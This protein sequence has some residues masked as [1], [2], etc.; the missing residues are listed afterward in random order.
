MS[1][2][3]GAEGSTIIIHSTKFG[4]LDVPESSVIEFR[5][6]LIGLPSA[7]RF[8]MF[9]YKAPFSWLHSV[10]DPSLAF[11]VVNGF[12]FG[13]ELNFKPPYGDKDIDLQQGDEFAILVI[14]TVRTDPRL[15]TAN[16]KA[17]LFVNLKNRKGTQIIFDDPRLTTRYSLWVEGDEAAVAAVSQA[18]PADKTPPDND[19]K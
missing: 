8:V 3:E 1:E 2:K 16:L 6:G 15:T 19:K 12:E 5:S 11:V 4:D 17:P 7:K 10:D 18:S 9:E 13:T 14:V